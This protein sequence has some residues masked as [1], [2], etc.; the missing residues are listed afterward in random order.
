MLMHTVYMYKCQIKYMK[1]FKKERNLGRGTLLF[2][3]LSSRSSLLRDFSNFLLF[4]L[5]S[6][7]AEST[8][9][10]DLVSLESMSTPPSCLS[11]S[12]LP[13]L[14]EEFLELSASSV[15]STTSS[16][17][18]LATEIFLSGTLSLS[19]V[20]F[21]MEEDFECSGSLSFELMS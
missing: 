9:I 2:F 11:V 1:S 20:S 10:S 21:V 17:S 16:P 12:R 4:S 3:F 18:R 7:P 8:E 5:P 14:L 19:S 6:S 15:E 13:R